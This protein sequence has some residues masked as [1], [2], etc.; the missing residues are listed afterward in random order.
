MAYGFH[1]SG[2]SV[3][4]SIFSPSNSPPIHHGRV[5]RVYFSVGLGGKYL[6]GGLKRDN[7]TEMEFR[8][9]KWILSRNIG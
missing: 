6:E 5:S 8:F 2:E 1:E 3:A 7:G 4:S 9:L